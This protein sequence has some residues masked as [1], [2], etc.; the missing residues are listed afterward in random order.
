MSEF[1]TQIIRRGLE[2]QSPY[3]F[4]K[5]MKQDILCVQKPTPTFQKGCFYL[6][7]QKPLK[8]DENVFYFMLKAL[9]GL[10]VFTFL[11]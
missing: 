1:K 6:L 4:Q 10:K 2:L 8:K 9:F 5:K 11:S 3:L 7:Q